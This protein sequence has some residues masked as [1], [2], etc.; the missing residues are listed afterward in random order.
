MIQICLYLKKIHSHKANCKAKIIMNVTSKSHFTNTNNYKYNFWLN[1]MSQVDHFGL[2]FQ[3]TM[4]INW[5]EWTFTIFWA[6]YYMY[7]LP[8]INSIIVLPQMIIYSFLPRF[9]PCAC[10]SVC[11]SVHLYDC[12]PALFPPTHFNDHVLHTV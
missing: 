5:P 4:A 10:L 8:H 7:I 3:Q 9:D 1:N 12:L 11:L 6:H 2:S